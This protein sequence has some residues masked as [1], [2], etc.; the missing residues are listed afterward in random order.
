MMGVSLT[1][2]SFYK[3]IQILS[4]N[5]TSNYMWRMKNIEE[6]NGE[7]RNEMKR[8][9]WPHLVDHFHFHS[10]VSIYVS[11]L[12]NLSPIIISTR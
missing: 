12:I 10:V 6:M 1:K 5:Q 4:T 9:S 8:K 7:I 3:H 2:Y 11:L